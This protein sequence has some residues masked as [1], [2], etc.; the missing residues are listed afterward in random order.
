MSTCTKDGT[1]GYCLQTRQ[2]ACTMHTEAE[3]KR[4][5]PGTV[6]VALLSDSTWAGY[7]R[8]EP[9]RVI[10]TLAELAELVKY[11]IEYTERQRARYYSVADDIL[12]AAGL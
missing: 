5:A 7:I 9:A 8:A 2:V 10:T 3:S 4:F 6:R 11:D 12:N 1:C